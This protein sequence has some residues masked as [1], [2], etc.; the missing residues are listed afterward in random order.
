MEALKLPNDGYV[1]GRLSKEL[2]DSLL[3]EAL[4]CESNDI[5]NT[6]LMTTS[7][8]QTCPHYSVSKKNADDLADF[9]MPYINH[10]MENFDYV[11]NIGVL[12]SDSPLVFQEP[13]YN[14]QKPNDYLPVHMHDGV[15]SYSIWLKL[16]LE[17]SFQ[18]S[19]SSIT[20]RSLDYGMKLSPNE[21]GTFLMF[22]STLT[23]AVYPYESDNSEETRITLSGN[24]SFRGISELFPK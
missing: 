14:V 7:G 17:S 2:F 21:A 12:T 24:I 5:V 8:K 11:Q 16:P 1:V 22:P 6:G 9:L 3:K 4:S 20:G 23:H 10:Y 18:F 15:L 13:W 19:Y